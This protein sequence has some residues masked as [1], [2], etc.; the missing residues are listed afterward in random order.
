M[1]FYLNEYYPLWLAASYQYHFGEAEKEAPLMDD[2]FWDGLAKNYAR[3]LNHFP[4][5]ERIGFDGSTM[6]VH[7]D[8]KELEAE[9]ARVS[10]QP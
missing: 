5:L 7:V 3:F 9:I 6:G 10:K 4:Y 8:P 2:T 1:L